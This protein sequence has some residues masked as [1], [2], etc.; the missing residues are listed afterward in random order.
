MK[1]SAL[2]LNMLHHFS[3]FIAFVY[4]S[5][6]LDAWNAFGIMGLSIT[7]GYFLED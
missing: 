6:T 4:W 1:I 5:K 2:G 3:L 7:I